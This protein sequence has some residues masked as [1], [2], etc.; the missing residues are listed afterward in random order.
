[1]PNVHPAADTGPGRL[2]RGRRVSSSLSEMNVVPLVDVMLVLLIIFMVA[3]PMIQR[4]IDVRLPVSTGASQIS[5]ERVY[6]TIRD[7]F[8][9]SQ[10]V[11]LGKEELRMEALQER[12]R[13]RMEA[14]ADKKVYLQADRRVVYD[15]IVKVIDVMKAAGVQDV[16][17]VTDI[18]ERR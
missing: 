3:S 12:V 15:D 10:R 1:M 7:D 6:V 2:G 11:F 16:G 4:G 5:G 8:R 9:Q 13:Q 18:P 17:L 14:S